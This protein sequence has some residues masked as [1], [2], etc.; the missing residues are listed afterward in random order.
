MEL[1]GWKL[2]E[3]I[4]SSILHIW[5]EWVS[6]FIIKQ[7]WKRCFSLQDDETT[8]KTDKNEIDCFNLITATNDIQY[9]R[10]KGVADFWITPCPS[11]LQ[12]YQ[13]NLSYLFKS[14]ISAFYN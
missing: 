7:Y 10:E 2:D 3:N 5:E 13:Q 8:D 6:Y 11:E 14:W 4:I 9:T 12:Q 1:H